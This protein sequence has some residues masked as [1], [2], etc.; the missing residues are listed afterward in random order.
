MIHVL[1]FSARCDTNKDCPDNSDE[2]NCDF[3]STPEGY[4]SELMPR[5]FEGPLKVFMNVSILAFPEIDTTAL[6]F[7]VDFFLSLR[8]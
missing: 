5:G 3:L 1:I 7:T 6:K 2:L 8:W 4:S